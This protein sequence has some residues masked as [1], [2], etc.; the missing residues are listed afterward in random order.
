MINDNTA[1]WL[2]GSYARGDFDTVSDR[3][4]FIVSDSKII[5]K[6]LIELLKINESH[7]SISQ[8]SWS[9]INKM[10]EYGSLF[11][12][13]LR[14]EGSVLWESK[15]CN[16]KLATIL[17]NLNDYNKTENDIRGFQTVLEDV[18]ESV[19]DGGSVLFELSVIATVLRHSSILGCWLLGNPSFGRIKP[20]EIYINAVGLNQ[21]IAKEFPS[22]YDYRLF[23][24]K[25][26]NSVQNP[27]YD[28]FSLWFERAN[29]IIQ[30]LKDI[31]NGCPKM[32]NTN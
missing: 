32:Y 12:Q 19:S 4:I 23:F 22:I 3:D 31:H 25:R 21:E 29:L 28:I 1:I 9:E 20:I 7:C 8:Y 10:A 13:H 16:G 30:K 24:D 6:E 11:L 15:S 2:Y 27:E 14:L 18:W 26:I 5:D 17:N